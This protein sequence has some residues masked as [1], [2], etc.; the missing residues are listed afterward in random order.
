[1]SGV[2]YVGF[3]FVPVENWEGILPTPK[4][5]SNWK[6][7]A[8]IEAYVQQK[9]IELRDGKAATEPLS[10]GVA[11]IVVLADKKKKPVFEIHNNPHAGSEFY[12]WFCGRAQMPTCAPFKPTLIGIK[13]HRAARLIALDVIGL[14]GMAPGMLQWAIDLDPEYRYNRSPGF[15]DPLSVLF[16]SSDTDLLGACR[17]LGIAE[18]VDRNNATSMAL[19]SRRLGKLLGLS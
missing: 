19:T 16:G 12:S 4:A 3:R 8:K 2:Y 15:I 17:R 1:M 18:L 11:G 13:I 14:T 9:L 5:P 6:D 10:G 7:P